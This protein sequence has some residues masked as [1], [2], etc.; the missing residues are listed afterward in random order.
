M[1]AL[2]ALVIFMGVLIVIGMGVLAWG[3]M[4]KLEEWQARESGDAPAVPV[5]S[6]PA[7][8]ATP[9]DVWPDMPAVA[10]PAGAQVAETIVAEGRLVIRLALAD[11][12]QRYLVFDL[13]TGRQLGAVA[14]QP[15]GAAQ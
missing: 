8:P 5:V 11:G 7:P 12:G 10:V 13:A 1:Q 6:A 9:A 15:G 14:L 4:Y 2:K 3:I